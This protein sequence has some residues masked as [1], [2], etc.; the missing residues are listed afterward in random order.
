MLDRFGRR[1]GAVLLLLL[2]LIPMS[3]AGVTIRPTGT[4]SMATTRDIH[5]LSLSM[6]L[7]PGPR[8]MPTFLPPPGQSL[9]LLTLTPLLPPPALLKSPRSPPRRLSLRLARAARRH[10]PGAV[11]MARRTG[12]GDGRRGQRRE[13]PVD[14][15]MDRFASRRGEPSLYHSAA[16]ASVRGLAVGGDVVDAAGGR[17]GAGGGKGRRGGVRWRCRWPRGGGRSGC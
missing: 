17:G 3:M 7:S 11:A 4:A 6:S 12:R 2:I 1:G 9:L 16:Q 8:P 13:L 15:P 14:I 10:F 5:I